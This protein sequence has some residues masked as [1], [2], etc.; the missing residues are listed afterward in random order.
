MD[1]L[2]VGI[3]ALLLGVTFGFFVGRGTGRNSAL[4]EGRAAGI[5]AGRLQGRAEGKREGSE[6]GRSEG[7]QEGRRKGLEE[8][9]A[10]GRAEGRAEGLEEGHAKGFEEGRVAAGE[11]V[12]GEEREAA[13]VEAIGRVSAFLHGQVGEPLSGVTGESDQE[14]LLERIAR[15]RGALED[16]D[17]FIAER[18]EVRQGSDLTRLA[19]SVSR[20][21]AGD[22]DV[23]VRLMLV[24]ATVRADVNP[25]ALM[26]ALYLVLHNA[27]RFGGGETIDLTVDEVG[28]RA[29]IVVRDRGKG[30]SEEA[31][32][33]AFDP[34][35]STSDEG[36]GLGLPHARK[37]VEAMGGA[38]ALRN[39][40][41]GGAEVEMSFPV[42]G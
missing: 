17:F 30:F 9:R 34:F 5:E 2:I 36:L 41:D 6:E 37:L 39:R 21:F 10:M 33:R 11:E 27:A 23:G 38:I 29:V 31:F 12:R 25:P 40:P 19:Q 15:A 13:L 16:L 8:G 20:E 24:R 4:S 14:E 42:S 28:R 7:F 1:P 18:S 3:T 32:K 35:Y 22:H 26:D